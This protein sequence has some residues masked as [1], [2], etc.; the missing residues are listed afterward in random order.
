MLKI[1][2]TRRRFKIQLKF[3][4]RGSPL[5]R[6]LLNKGFLLTKLKSFLRKVYSRHHGLVDRHGIP[7]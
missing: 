5:I 1:L 3:I 7:V 6:G 2:I 4:N